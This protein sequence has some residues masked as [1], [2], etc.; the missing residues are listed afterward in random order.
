MVR[1]RLFIGVS[2]GTVDSMINNY[3][4]NKKSRSDDQYSE[5]GVGG[6]R[7]DYA[8]I[9]YA[10]LARKARSPMIYL[11]GGARGASAAATE[12]VER[13]FCAVTST[14]G[15]ATVAEN[16]VN[17]PDLLATICRGLGID[18]AKENM[19]NIGR[20]IPLADRTG[21]PIEAVLSSRIG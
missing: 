8:S 14:N 5:G 2:S 7:P 3:T 11:G 4:A 20:P 1:P 17:V 16:P 21:K 18:P 6:K 13:G 10:D 19:S 15:R 9:V 12:L